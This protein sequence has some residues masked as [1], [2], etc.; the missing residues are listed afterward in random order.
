MYELYVARNI[1][2]LSEVVFTDVLDSKLDEHCWI[3]MV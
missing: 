2:I 3:G 1:E